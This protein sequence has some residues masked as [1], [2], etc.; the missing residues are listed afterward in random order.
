M[1]ATSLQM[2][3]ASCRNGSMASGAS[4]LLWEVN[5]PSDSSPFPLSHWIGCQYKM[6]SAQCYG[7][8]LY[9]ARLEPLSGS[10]RKDYLRI[11]G[12]QSR[13]QCDWAGAGCPLKMC[14][15][16]GEDCWR[17]L[18]A[19]SELIKQPAFYSGKGN[20]IGGFFPIVLNDLSVCHGLIVL[21]Q[22]AVDRGWFSLK[23]FFAA[24]ERDCSHLIQSPG[25]QI[26]LC[27]SINRN[28]GFMQFLGYWLL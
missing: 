25:S 19:P 5:K 27:W 9:W 6:Q 20:A 15:L 26:S 24:L 12:L 10:S 7:F 3:T 8:S 17:S 1:T 13:I 11:L 4:G 28:C 18:S 16:G 14:G 23:V 2:L 21:L 22:R